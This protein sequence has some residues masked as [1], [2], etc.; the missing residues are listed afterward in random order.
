MLPKLPCSWI[1]NLNDFS[2]SF[3][4][5]LKKCV[6]KIDSDRN[7]RYFKDWPRKI[8][9]RIVNYTN[10]TFNRTLFGTWSVENV[11]FFL[12]SPIKWFWAN[13]FAL[14]TRSKKKDKH[15]MVT[16]KLLIIN[17][18]AFVY[19]SLIRL[20]WLQIKNFVL[21][22]CVCFLCN[23]NLNIRIETIQSY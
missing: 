14:F 18:K 22:R 7:L 15:F 21:G 20:T 6:I 16:R 23:K 9:I 12:F 13:E 10:K 5:Q 3:G 11:F 19:T 4:Y 2:L 8:P 17:Q 1:H